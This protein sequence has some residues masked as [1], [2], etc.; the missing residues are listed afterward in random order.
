VHVRF[1]CFHNAARSQMA[2]GFFEQLAGHE[3]SACSAGTHP[4]KVLNPQVSK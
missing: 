2:Q 3:H 4:A 1:V